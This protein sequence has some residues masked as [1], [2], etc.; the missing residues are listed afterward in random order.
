MTMTNTMP[1]TTPRSL[2]VLVQHVRASALCL[3]CLAGPGTACARQGRRGVHLDRFVQAYR[4]GSIT[5]AETA[6]TIVE[7]VDRQ[8]YYRHGVASIVRDGF[9]SQLRPAAEPD[10]APQ[11][12]VVVN[13]GRAA[14]VS[15]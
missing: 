1:Q 15:P 12:Y 14:A 6:L 8:T 9:C 5:A 2:E 11:L 13:V 10:Q 4:D 7:G 3:H